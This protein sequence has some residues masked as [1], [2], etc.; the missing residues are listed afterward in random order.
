MECSASY[1]V[2]GGKLIKVRLVKE[3][4]IIISISIFGDFFIHPEESIDVLEN[5]LK[6]VTISDAEKKIYDFFKSVELVGA[7]ADDFVN[8]VKLAYYK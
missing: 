8:T 2:K 7:N 6:N 1:K 5:S 3:D 4:D